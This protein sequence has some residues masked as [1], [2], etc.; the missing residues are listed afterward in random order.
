[1]TEYQDHPFSALWPL[2]EGE[3]FDKLVAD[4]KANGL[5]LPILLYRGKIL[6]GRNRHRACLDAGVSPRVESAAAKDDD[7]ALN[8]VISLNEQRLHLSFEQR[9]F[10]GAR[11]V[12]FKRAW[13]VNN[14]SSEKR[15]NA[16]QDTFVPSDVDPGLAH[17]SVLVRK[18]ARTVDVAPGSITR[19]RNIIH[20]APE[21]EQE[22]VAKKISLATAAN[23]VR[24]KRQPKL[25]KLRRLLRKTAW[26]RL[27]ERTAAQ[28]KNQ[29]K[30]TPEQID[31]EFS[32]TPMEFTT[33]YGH[34]QVETAEERA[35][36]HF[37][38]W[39]IGIGHIARVLDH[40]QLPKEV[41]LNWLRSP[42]RADFDRISAALDKLQPIIEQAKAMRDRAKEALNSK[43]ET[44]A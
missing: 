31:P 16:S 22:I 41:D 34:V 39:A 42:N 4:I 9:A 8:L 17:G 2:L 36:S 11:L 29:R 32:G 14:R 28:L 35:R 13:R 12:N 23:Q 3:D 21:L 15:T 27:Q 5:R 1:M 30:L 24:P 26:E 25:G 6:D 38:D 40:Q 44:A 20:Y 33:K 10:A 43:T 37:S 18:A 19:A 7:E